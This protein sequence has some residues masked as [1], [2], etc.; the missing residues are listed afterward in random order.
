MSSDPSF[1]LRAVHLLLI[2]SAALW[3]GWLLLARADFLYPVAYRVLDIPATLEGYVPHNRHGKRDFLQT[4]AAEHARLFAAMAQA[5]RHGGE[6]LEALRYR[7]P[8]GRALGTL[9]TQDEVNHLRDV[10]RLVGPGERAGLLAFLGWLG[11]VALMLARGREPPRARSLVLGSLGL[12][13]LA[14]AALLAVGPV[15]AFYAL[16]R[17]IF[18]PDHPWFFYYQDSLMSSL[19]QA[20][21]L[22]GFIGLLWVFTAL[23]ILLALNYSARLAGRLVQYWRIK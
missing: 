9:L 23:A 16:H 6:G 10:A 11:L 14:G 3:L 12:L 4:D 21:R 5:I 1:P 8:D 18:P 20:P 7:A 19:M 2:G 17:W 13:A 22:F 15:E